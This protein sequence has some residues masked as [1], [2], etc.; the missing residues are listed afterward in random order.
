MCRPR[1]TR[2]CSV[3]VALRRP[4]T[5]LLDN[6]DSADQV[7]P[8]LPPSGTVIVTSRSRLDLPGARQIDVAPLTDDESARLLETLAGQRMDEVAR[9]CGG[10]PLSIVLMGAR[11]STRHETLPSPDEPASVEP[12]LDLSYVELPERQAR[13]YRL[14]A[15]QPAR[16]RRSGGGGDRG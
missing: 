1:I 6:A 2:R 10:L 12:L 8:L 4:F 7:T 3:S 16:I 9:W 13:L 11:L 15:W 5:L 14:C